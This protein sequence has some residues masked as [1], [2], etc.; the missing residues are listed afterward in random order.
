MTGRLRP[1]SAVSLAALR[2]VGEHTPVAVER[3]RAHE[4]FDPLWQTGHL[5]RTEAYR[6]LASAMG[7]P[8]AKTHIEQFNAQQCRE[9][10]RLVAGRN[11]R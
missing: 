5:S 4:A 3:M 8:A 1:Y 11:T 2:R 10:V 7:L 6:W 9:V